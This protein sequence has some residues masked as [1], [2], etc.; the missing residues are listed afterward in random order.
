MLGHLYLSD[1]RML[2]FMKKV[3]SDLFQILNV[4]KPFLWRMEKRE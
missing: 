4:S 2:H 1:E 3:Q